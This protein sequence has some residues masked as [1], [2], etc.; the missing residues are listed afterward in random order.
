MMQITDVP[1]I[2][3]G[4]ATDAE[5]ATGCTVILC[6]QGAVGGVDVRGSA[7]GTRETD[8]LR[9]MNLV[10]R[11]HAVLLAGG[12]AFGLAAA[13]GVMRFLEERGIGFDAGVARVPI[14]PAAALFDLGVGDAA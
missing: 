12:S 7:P 6:T 5:A 1:G 8:L 2:K 10:E 4:H 14:V 9:P 13:D 11:V 3:V